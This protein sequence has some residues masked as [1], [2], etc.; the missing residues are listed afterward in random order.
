L[1]A[2]SNVFIQQGS[3]KTVGPQSLKQQ[4]NGSNIPGPLESRRRLE[5]R[6]MGVMTH[7]DLGR[8]S[9][10]GAGNSVLTWINQLFTP[11]LALDEWSW[12]AP[13]HN[14]H[15]VREG[16]GTDTITTT[17]TLESIRSEFWTPTPIDE[18]AIVASQAALT[19]LLDSA[20][21]NDFDLSLTKEFFDSDMNISLGMNISRLM[22]WS[23][24]MTCPAKVRFYCCKLVSYYIGHGRIS[25]SEISQISLLMMNNGKR[26]CGSIE[27]DSMIKLMADSFARWLR[28]H[29]NGSQGGQAHIVAQS[30]V[31]LL[32]TLHIDVASLTR[33]TVMIGDL[34]LTL[35]ETHLDSIAH[36]LI[37]HLRSDEQLIQKYLTTMK[38]RVK[39]KSPHLHEWLDRIIF[40]ITTLLVDTVE[41]A[42]I[43]SSHLKNWL[44]HLHDSHK[45]EPFRKETWTRLSQIVTSSSSSNVQILY[46]CIS[47]QAKFP[48][49]TYH[50][51]HG[52]DFFELD[53]PSTELF[54]ANLS[55]CNA[56]QLENHLYRLI[57]PTSKRQLPFSR[58]KKVPVL[59]RAYPCAS[60][61]SIHVQQLELLA[62]TISQT[63]QLSPQ[64]A[65]RLIWKL[66]RFLR[67]HQVPVSRTMSRAIIHAGLTRPFQENKI[68]DQRR[69]SRIIRIVNQAE[70]SLIASALDKEI[71]AAV[72]D[73]MMKIGKSKMVNNTK[74]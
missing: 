51:Y 70:G 1:D 68:I 12:Q 52:N 61:M 18:M 43:N 4:R 53:G 16:E 31:D 32:M 10:Y 34:P 7:Y 19:Y 67:D 5:K 3:Q 17:D 9:Q 25:P 6:R 69:W 59:H 57:L 29:H 28:R 38:R 27:Q 54:S 65:F 63:S 21:K 56:H 66:Y 23:F 45:A 24:G 13:S 8:P 41:S 39:L 37:N 15:P 73:T 30:L 46:S 55:S 62:Q 22:E 33:M 74:D 20:I 58:K 42:P 64:R 35:R 49:P 36:R 48:L 26:T 40:K 11:Y 60:L 47:P 2:L 50:V 71:S 44:M 14:D 72:A